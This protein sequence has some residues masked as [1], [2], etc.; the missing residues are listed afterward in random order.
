[1]NPKRDEEKH[2]HGELATIKMQRLSTSMQADVTSNL[3]FL[4]A[5]LFS[6]IS[7]AEKLF[8]SSY[9]NCIC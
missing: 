4:D 2:G 6:A 9:A 1:M 7:L 5:I 3:K 8:F